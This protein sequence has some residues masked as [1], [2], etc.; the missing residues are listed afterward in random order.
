[1][2]VVYKLIPE[3]SAF[4]VEQK[5]NQPRLTCQALS[6]MVMEKFGQQVSK[7][8]VHE[9]LKQSHVII[10]RARKTKEKFQIPEH[11]KEQIS[12]SLAPFVAI[13]MP[14]IKVD[15]PSLVVSQVQTAPVEVPVQAAPPAV[16]LQ[17][18]EPPPQ[19]VTVTPEVHVAPPV[20]VYKEHVHV[21]GQGEIFLKSALYDLS[22]KPVLG[23]SD[24]QMEISYNDK[25]K[26]EWEYLT[27][28]VAAIK[29]ELE[30][31]TYFYIDPRFQGIYPEN[32]KDQLLSAPI[33]RA[34]CEAADYILNNI[35]PIIIRKFD[36]NDSNLIVYDFIAAMQNIPGKRIK[37]ILV[38]DSNEKILTE[39]NQPL[40]Y[41][42][43]YIISVEAQH[44]D[45]KWFMEE[46][47]TEGTWD[48]PCKTAGLTAKAL[49]R[50]DRIIITN[51]NHYSYDEIVR[52]HDQR[53]PSKGLQ[54]TTVADQATEELEDQKQ[55]VKNRLQQR[56]LMFFPSDFT[57][58]HLDSVLGLEGY[59]ELLKDPKGKSVVDEI[60][61]CLP[62][63]F[64]L[65][66]QLKK[67]AE[68][69]NSLNILNFKG[70]KIVICV[71]GSSE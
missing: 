5:R 24:E 48:I 66:G 20:P 43:Q 59:Q 71:D 41:K 44:P 61:L 54:I 12:K 1:M 33:E 40:M 23:I 25:L 14:L 26:L 49:K 18:P 19:P 3:I 27:S 67:A 52:Q 60:H 2:G 58:K 34:A 6:S 57:L 70:E 62:K 17:A 9:L 31:Q 45:F 28:Q 8:S 63:D 11:R 10:P 53:H 13:G 65:Q 30:D 42:R 16:V 47:V 46:S 55:W 29:V 7:S 69:L 56:A 51:L 50:Q 21:K 39:F 4:I 32:P 64:L 37:K 36:L 22:F 68:N 38:I 35:K 15:P